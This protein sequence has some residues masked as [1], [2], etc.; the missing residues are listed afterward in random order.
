M[1]YKVEPD[2]PLTLHISIPIFIPCVDPDPLSTPGFSVL[3]PSCSFASPGWLDVG[4]G[5]WFNDIYAQS[6]LNKSSSLCLHTRGAHVFFSLLHFSVF[7]SLSVSFCLNVH[8]S[9]SLHVLKPPSCSETHVFVPVL[10]L[11]LINHSIC[12]CILLICQRNTHIQGDCW[13]EWAPCLL[14]LD[15]S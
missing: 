13:N 6:L 11:T 14:R 3:P 15:V 2:V 4:E 7:P 9:L 8:L 5:S 10:T 12:V 1:A